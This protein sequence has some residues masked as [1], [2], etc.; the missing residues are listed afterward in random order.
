[1]K[2]YVVWWG[3]DFYMHHEVWP[4]GWPIYIGSSIEGIKTWFYGQDRATHIFVI[5]YDIDSTV[6]EKVTK[7][8]FSK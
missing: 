4:I 6:A 3:E 8:V 1:M 5:E 7:F 2:V